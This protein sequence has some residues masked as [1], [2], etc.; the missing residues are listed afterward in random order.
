M[1]FAV[2]PVEL[3]G[4]RRL[5][6]QFAD[7]GTR[8]SVVLEQVQVGFSNRWYARCPDACDRRARM[9]YLVPGM[10]RFTCR[11]CAGL[12]YES[13][14]AHDSRIDDAR[15][16]PSSWWEGRDRLRGR[17]SLF[18]TLRLWDEA[19]RRGVQWVSA[20]ALRRWL[21]E[22]ASAEEREILERLPLSTLV[23]LP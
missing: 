5:R 20:E 19:V 16:N 3:G 14:R 23:R 9:L 17:R 13:V 10:Q 7:T 11:Q 22:G 15:R 21:F 8:Q 4:I 12:E 2:G 18:V 6:L 1:T